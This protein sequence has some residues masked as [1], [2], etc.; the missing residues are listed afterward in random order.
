MTIWTWAVNFQNLQFEEIHDNQ[1]EV[2]RIYSEK[3][4]PAEQCVY[5]W[6]LHGR[7]GL[8]LLT[9]GVLSGIHIDIS[10]IQYIII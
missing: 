6:Q 1:L 3:V 10:G 9:W 2:L 7:N 5:V 4:N 8:S